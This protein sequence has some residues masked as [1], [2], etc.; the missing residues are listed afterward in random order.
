MNADLTD[1]AEQVGRGED[2]T[3]ALKEYANNAKLRKLGLIGAGLAGEELARRT[4][5]LGTIANKVA[6]Q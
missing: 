3:G 2:Y 4:G 1:A 5:L 6:G